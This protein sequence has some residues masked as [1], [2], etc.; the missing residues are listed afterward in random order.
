MVIDDGDA[1]MQLDIG[2]LQL[3]TG[4]EEGRA[5]RKGR[6]DEAL[7]MPLP[8]QQLAQEA[9]AADRAQAEVVGVAGGPSLREIEVILQVLAHARQGVMQGDAVRQDVLGPARRT[10]AAIAASRRPRRR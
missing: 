3:R 5:F 9:Q 10:I 6:G 2:P 8:G 4:L 7:A 1:E